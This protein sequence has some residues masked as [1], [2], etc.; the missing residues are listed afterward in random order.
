MPAVG[1]P[2]FLPSSHGAIDKQRLQSERGAAMIIGLCLILFM[3][4]AAALVIDVARLERAALSLQQAADAASLAGASALRPTYDN[5]V[6]TEESTCFH[7]AKVA[8]FQLLA[9]NPVLG[10]GG[11]VA[12]GP[13]TSTPCL[14][15]PASPYDL[16]PEWQCVEYDF[17]SMRVR[18]ERGAYYQ[19]GSEL[20]FAPLDSVADACTVTELAPHLTLCPSGP[21]SPVEVSNGIKVRLTLKRIPTAFAGILGIGEVTGVS[22]ESVSAKAPYP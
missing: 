17:T 20:H 5:S 13:L 6:S 15:L 16:A 18:I 21:A 10:E 3:L 8:V 4:F 2:V 7:G 1:W 14:D 19:Q 11:E 12:A 9:E 22:R